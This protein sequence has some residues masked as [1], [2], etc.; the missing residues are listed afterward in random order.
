MRELTEKEIEQV[1]GGVNLVTWAF[2][3]GQ[4]GSAFTLG[5]EAG[6]AINSFNASHTMPLGEALYRTFN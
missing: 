6:N 2:R 1:Q 5:L 4:F 3:T